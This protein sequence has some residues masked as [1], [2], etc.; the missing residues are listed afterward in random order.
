MTRCPEECGKQQRPVQGKS[1][2][3]KQKEEKGQGGSKEE[4]RRAGEEETKGEKVGRGK[5][6][7]KGMGNLERGEGSGKVRSGG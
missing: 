4:I 6:S 7:S 5:E 3:E 2:Q 1:D